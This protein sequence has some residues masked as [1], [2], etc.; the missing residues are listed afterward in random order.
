M[1]EVIEAI[2][3]EEKEAK[4]RV[5]KAREEAKKIRSD[6]EDKAKNIVSKSHEEVQQAGKTLIEQ[7]RDRANETREEQLRASEGELENFWDEHQT[8]IRGT[9]NKMFHLI[10]GDR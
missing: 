4:A 7:A 10:T 3:D 1:K 2:L 8:E 9:I 6:A 5:N